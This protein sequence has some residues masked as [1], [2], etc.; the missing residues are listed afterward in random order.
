[1]AQ[2]EDD[3]ALPFAIEGGAVRGRVVRLGP[4][5]HRVISGHGYGAGPAKLAGE[6]LTLVSL[7]GSALK[8]EGTLTL[9]TRGDGA[10]KMVV[11]DYRTPGHVRAVVSLEPGT[12]PDAPLL[13]QGSFALTIDPDEGQNRYQGVVELKGSLR[14]AA[15]LYFAQSEQIPTALKLAVG[16]AQDEGDDA[17]RW[18]AGGILVQ[19]V[20]AEGGTPLTDAQADDWQRVTALVETVGADELLD[21]ALD[22]ERL[23]YRLFHEDAV[24]GFPRQPIE[25]RCRC[26]QERVDRIFA[27]YGPEELGDL[28]DD[29]GK[30]RMTCE[31]CGTAYVAN[32]T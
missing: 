14:E 25:F 18:R 24:R 2:V 6:A 12:E 28:R 8:F 4:A 26:S 20:A 10:A 1:M 16:Q 23:A 11:A 27:T 31:F 5:A 32:E 15:L 13:G 30:V 22:G 21:P 17:P 29:D 19:R 9:Q 3:Y 7:L